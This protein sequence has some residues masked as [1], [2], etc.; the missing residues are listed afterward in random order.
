[1]KRRSV[2]LSELLVLF[3]CSMSLKVISVSVDQ[4]ILF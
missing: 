4:H 3:C 2:S 1:M